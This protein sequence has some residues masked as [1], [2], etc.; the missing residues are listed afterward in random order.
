V[1]IL[2]VLPLLVICLCLVMPGCGG[3]ANAPTSVTIK[4]AERE[5]SAGPGAEGTGT[6]G[7][8][9]PTGAPGSLTGRFTFNGTAPTLAPLVTKGEAVKDAQYC[10]AEAVPNQSLIVGPDGGIQDVFI[11]LSEA[12]KGYK[13][14]GELESLVLDQKNCTFTPHG[15]VLQTE[16]TLLIENDDGAAHNTNIQTVRNTKFN[17]VVE[18]NDRKGRPH[19]FE[20]PERTPV[21]VKCDFHAW[22]T[23]HLLILDHPFAAC[24]KPDGTFEIKNLPP[25]DYVFLVWHESA[26]GPGL[27]ERRLKV[28]IKPGEEK[29][30]EKSYGIGDFPKL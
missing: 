20:K 14:E 13:R 17:Q 29:K 24:S 30:I 6:Q 15:L 7:P 23:A 21:L 18:P 1:V 2:A 4:P 27:L 16:Q 9:Q 19:V 5:A 22:M 11:Y 25:G 26:G 10:S 12:P 3:G 28:T 8:S